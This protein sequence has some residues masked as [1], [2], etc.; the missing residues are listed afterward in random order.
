M[1]GVFIESLIFCN[2]IDDLYQT[3]FKREYILKFERDYIN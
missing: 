1:N 3:R 2:Y